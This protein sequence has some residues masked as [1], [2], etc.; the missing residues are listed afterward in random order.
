MKKIKWGNIFKTILFFGCLYE[1]LY[2]FY[3]IVIYPIITTKII[4]FTWLGLIIC[5]LCSSYI[6]EYIKEVY[7]YIKSK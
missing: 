2:D 4:T 3:Y 1:V 5:I 7:T 6:V